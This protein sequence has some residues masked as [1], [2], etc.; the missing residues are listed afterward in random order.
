MVELAEVQSNGAVH[1]S[2][3]TE[4]MPPVD[5]PIDE[6]AY[7]FFPPLP[8]EIYAALER[9]IR[10][11][12]IQ[13]PIE[14]DGEGHVLDG[15]H[16][17]A[18]ARKL[19]WSDDKIRQHIRV[20]D[21]LDLESARIEYC[22][23][24]N[25]MRRQKISPITWAKAALTL[26]DARGIARGAKHNGWTNTSDTVS[27]VFEELGVHPRTARR[28]LKLYDMFWEDETYRHLGTQIECGTLEVADAK[29]TRQEAE[30]PSSPDAGTFVGVAEKIRRATSLYGTKHP[31]ILCTVDSNE[32]DGTVLVKVVVNSSGPEATPSGPNAA[33]KGRKKSA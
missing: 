13:S 8:E 29:R 2:V 9:D 25:L 14:V 7:Q 6:Q 23:K 21:D 26:L 4:K 30:A 10:R 24:A 27:A 11:R 32:A 1:A 3:L 18:I 15:H 19:G 16:R 31:G 12:G 28:H 20:R 5:L 22:I 33:K 17:L